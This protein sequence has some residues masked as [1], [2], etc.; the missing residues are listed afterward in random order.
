M[1]VVEN[2]GLVVKMAENGFWGLEMLKK[3]KW[4]SWGSKMAVT[5]HR[6]FKIRKHTTNQVTNVTAILSIRKMFWTGLMYLMSY[7]ISN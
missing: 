1:I 5:L 6:S 4:G 7:V 2:G 3:V